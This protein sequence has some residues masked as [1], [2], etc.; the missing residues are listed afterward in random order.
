MVSIDQRG[1][2]MGSTANLLKRGKNCV[3]YFV[4][5]NQLPFLHFSSVLVRPRRIVWEVSSVSGGK[6]L[7]YREGGF[8]G[9]DSYLTRLGGFHPYIALKGVDWTDD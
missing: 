4:Y 2:T 8:F 7:Q 6:F 9:G 5:E 1:P 3:F